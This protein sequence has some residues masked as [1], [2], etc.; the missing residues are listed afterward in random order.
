MIAAHHGVPDLAFR[1]VD[2]RNGKEQGEVGDFL[3]WVGDVVAI[4]NRRSVSR[5]VVAHWNVT[6]CYLGSERIIPAWDRSDVTAAG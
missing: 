1:P 2:V 5:G 4:V 3:L 6:L